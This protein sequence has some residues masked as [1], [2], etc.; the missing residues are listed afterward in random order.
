MILSHSGLNLYQAFSNERKRAIGEQWEVIV[1]RDPILTNGSVL[2]YSVVVSPNGQ[3]ILLAV[4]VHSTSTSSDELAAPSAYM[5]Y[6]FSSDGFAT[7]ELAPESFAVLLDENAANHTYSDHMTQ[8]RYQ[9]VGCM[10]ISDDGHFFH[11]FTRYT[12]TQ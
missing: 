11:S 1:E 4:K 8:G 5:R 9:G 12:Y 7:L 3:Y 10:D 2:D 6:Y